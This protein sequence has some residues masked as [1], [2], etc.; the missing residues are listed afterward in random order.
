MLKLL[1]RN[2]KSVGLIPGTVIHTDETTIEQVRISLIGYDNASFF[3]KNIEDIDECLEYKNSKFVIWINIDGIQN[4]EIINKIGKHFNIHT[5]AL[6]DIT[7]P[8]PR[9]PIE[10]YDNYNFF[11]LKMLYQSEDDIFSEQISIIQNKNFVISFQEKKG[12][13]FDIIRDR[14]RNYKGRIRSLGSDYLT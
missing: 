9:P 6:E 8:D 1:N 10:E 13:V 3:E 5:L 11:V 4:S 2:L 7:N 12:D 14:I